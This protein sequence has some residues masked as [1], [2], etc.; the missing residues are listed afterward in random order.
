VKV[1]LRN[2]VFGLGRKGDVTDVADGY[3]RNYLLP[4]GL[5]L[6]ATPGVEAQAEA[7][8]RTRMLRNAADKAEAQALAQVL[9]TTTIQVSAKA[10]REGK[11]FGSVGAA[12]IAT[13]ITAQSGAR[14]ERKQ[15]DLAEPIKAV[16][17]YQVTLHLYTDV[18]AAV[19]VDV[20]A[21]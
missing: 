1:V 3:A 15:V 18:D 17:S 7:M 5:A 20:V 2:D 19:T 21:K 13:A 16:G 8:R 4:K 10:G 6:R 12:D 9:G 11:L 14:L